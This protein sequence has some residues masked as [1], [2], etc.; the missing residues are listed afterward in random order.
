MKF[1]TEELKGEENY[2][3]LDRDGKATKKYVFYIRWNLKPDS[4]VLV[5]CDAG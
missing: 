2:I 4:E 1:D 5:T 3:F